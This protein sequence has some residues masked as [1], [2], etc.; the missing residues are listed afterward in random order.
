MTWRDHVVSSTARNRYDHPVLELRAKNSKGCFERGNAA[1]KDART[2]NRLV[3]CTFLCCRR[4]LDFR[5]LVNLT[6][7]RGR[8]R[9]ILKLNMIENHNP[10]AIRLPVADVTLL[11]ASGWKSPSI[12]HPHSV[13]CKRLKGMM[14]LGLR[15]AGKTVLLN[16]LHGIAEKEGLRMA[17]V[18]APQGGMLPQ[19]LVPELGQVHYSLDLEASADSK[20]IGRPPCS[21]TLQLRSRSKSAISKLESTRAGVRPTPG[22]S[23]RSSP[24]CGS[25]DARRQGARPGARDCSRRGTVLVARRTGFAY[26]CVP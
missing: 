22:I 16:R 3:P 21:E 15:G 25:P 2:F 5:S 24:I 14:L 7:P 6:F 17:K 23:N 1:G 9:K 13:H 8:H 10:R 11:S 12:N 18:E 19:L 20:F 26:R 4:Y